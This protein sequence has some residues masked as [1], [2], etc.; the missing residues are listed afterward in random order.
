MRSRTRSGT[1]LI[2][3][4]TNSGNRFRRRGEAP[5]GHGVTPAP[6][7]LCRCL[8]APATPLRSLTGLVEG[9][10]VARARVERLLGCF[11]SASVVARDWG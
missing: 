10:G 7:I 8:N 2:D 5:L 1:S 9:S 3:T 11:E 4:P 6:Q